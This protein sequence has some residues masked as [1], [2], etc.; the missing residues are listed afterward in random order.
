MVGSDFFSRIT[1]RWRTAI[2]FSCAVL[3]SST[4]TAAP[5]TL[6]QLPLFFSAG[7]E[8]NIM[9]LFDNSGSMNSIIPEA[10]YDPATVYFNCPSGQTI[11]ATNASIDIR[12]TS[13][14]I[15]FFDHYSYSGGSLS[16]IATRDWGISSGSGP[17]GY[18][19]SCFAPGQQYRAALFGN[20][21]CDSCE[22]TPSYLGGSYSG[23]FL[24]WYFGW[25]SGASTGNQAVNFGAGGRKKPGTR[26]RLEVAKVAATDLVSNSLNNTRVGL[27]SYNGDNGA[28]ID[29]GVAAIDSH[30]AALAATINNYVANGNTPLAESLHDI[31]RYY[32]GLSGA[33]N[34]G[35]QTAPSV[36]TNG[37]YDGVLTLHPGGTAT[38]ADDDTVFDHSPV[39]A[40]GVSGESPIAYACQQNFAV[41]LTDGRPNGDREINAS[42]GLL[43]YDGDCI[44][45]SPACNSYDRKPG[46]EYEWLGSDYLDDVA[47]ALF[48]ID[49]RPD[50]DDANGNPVR[51]NVVTYTIGFADDQVINDPL[52][53]DTAANGGGEF[54]T[55]AASANALSQAFQQVLRNIAARTGSA[56]AAAFNGGSF[57][58]DS[59][60][61]L[62]LFHSPE[63]RGQLLAY[64]LDDNTGALGAAPV[65]D[66]GTQLA[67][68]N[69]ATSPRVILSHANGDG[70]ALRWAD[71]GVNQQHDLCSGPEALCD[72]D[73]AG[74]PD[75]SDDVIVGDTSVAEARLAFLRGDHGNEGTGFGFRQRQD[76]LGNT[77]RLGDIVH[78][79]TVYVGPPE[80]GWPDTLPGTTPYS[81]FYSD[82]AVQARTPVVYAGANDGM[83]HGFRASDGD[84]GAGLH[85]GGAVQRPARPGAASA[86]LAGLRP[87]L[88]CRF[89]T[90]NLRRLRTNRQR[91]Q[92]RL[93]HPADRRPARRRARLFRPGRDRP[94]PV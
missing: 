62:T 33:V 2:T 94:E 23:N 17:I 91:R 6:P 25:E 10:P 73:D 21:G 14:G 27:A 50:I 8:P 46:Q 88:L 29:A 59:R 65:W 19:K 40:A 39:L 11:S 43:D 83:L 12:I 41:L 69:L 72:L 54:I 26:T 92:R 71:L 81:D 77:F 82:A 36:A 48:E 45:A 90:G 85:A 60:L 20:L 32:V 80:T 15:P 63:W 3:A 58:A 66:A 74:T 7:S 37:Q 18:G 79:G 87:S 1:R 55:A 86:Q 31:G 38:S 75:P 49:L 22:K 47:R 68:R 24:N 93:A 16:H 30:R 57:R 35:A 5:G 28:R 84:R 52:M 78:G 56:A 34:P 44:G 64:P 4:T 89:K 61:Y 51:N 13:S 9:L 53:Q 67:T 70:V 42:T 76:T